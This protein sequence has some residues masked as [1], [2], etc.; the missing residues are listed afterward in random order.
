MNKSKDC[1]SENNKNKINNNNSIKC[2]EKIYNKE[3]ISIKSNKVRKHISL[4]FSDNL[5][6]N[7]KTNITTQSYNNLKKISNLSYS[8]PLI[9]TS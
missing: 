4:I 1:S 5:N 3:R 6:S 2:S 8:R 9:V 7:I